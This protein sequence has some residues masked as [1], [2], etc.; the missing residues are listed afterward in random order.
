MLTR[1]LPLSPCQLEVVDDQEKAGRLRR[2]RHKEGGDA[3][4]DNLSPH[5]GDAWLREKALLDEQHQPNAA[6]RG[7]AAGEPAVSLGPLVGKHREVLGT[8]FCLEEGSRGVGAAKAVDDLLLPHA[9]R[10][11]RDPQ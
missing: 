3:A 7:S 8:T 2:M 9:L 1:L 11:R 4:R 10:W 5:R 6:V